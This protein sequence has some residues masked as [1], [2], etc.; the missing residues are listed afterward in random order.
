MEG[1]IE[2]VSY[3][4]HLIFPST[5]PLRFHVSQPKVWHIQSIRLAYY[6]FVI[7][8]ALITQVSHPFFTN[9]QIW[10]S[11]YSVI[12]FALALH[13]SVFLF[14]KKESH[15]KYEICIFA[16]DAILIAILNFLTFLTYP[17][18][19]I[20]HLINISLCSFLL[21]NSKGLFLTGLTCFLYTITFLSRVHE[22]G[23]ANPH[24]LLNL[25]VFYFT[26]IISGYLGET[27]LSRGHLL[28][29]AKKE[30]G[31]LQG[32]SQVIIKNIGNGLLVFDSIGKVQIFNEAAQKIFGPRVSELNLSDFDK[33]HLSEQ[34][35]SRVEVDV[36]IN[37][38]VKNLE[39]ITTSLQESTEEFSQNPSW[40]SLVQDL[41][42]VKTLQKELGLKEKLAAVGQL[43]GGIAHEIRNP[44]ASISGSVEMLHQ[45][46]KDLNPE[47]RKLFSIII[48]EIERLNLLI[49]DFLSF[50]HPEVQKFDEVVLKNFIEDIFSLVHF[51]KNLVGLTQINFEQIN[52]EI[53][54]VAI[55]CDKG[56]LKQAFLNIITNGLQALHGVKDPVFQT[57][58]YNVDSHV[59]IE[60][61]DNGPGISKDKGGRVFEPFYTTKDKGTG[62]GLAI[63]HRIIEG[64]KGQIK[65]VSNG[66]K[67]TTFSIKLPIT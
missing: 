2:I 54:E 19:I 3:L 58:V 14:D 4:N 53:E 59:I 40:V 31:A 46:I 25:I 7:A 1:K 38:N 34:P 36:N 33:T 16:L 41:T 11:V 43:A 17:S 67:G 62:L 30:L 26:S 52:F 42:E 45:S 32:L 63:T 23:I 39:F 66:K 13:C 65:V 48:R 10:F 51:D 29:Q 6:L 9:S 15:K 18:F 57:K 24:Y 55:K 28:S 12:I 5:E 37:D 50:V 44:L 35:V 49:T 47:N 21:G 61:T 8:L 56:K 22:V 20:L 64:H 27:Y 60:F